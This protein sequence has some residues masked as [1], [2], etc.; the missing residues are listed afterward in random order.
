MAVVVVAW[1]RL[2]RD[3]VAAEQ[4]GSGRKNKSNQPEVLAKVAAAVVAWR[5]LPC[6]IAVAA[7][8]VAAEK[9]KTINWRF[10][11]R[12]QR[13]WWPGGDC[14]A[15]SLRQCKMEPLKK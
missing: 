2:P 12:W 10:W 13:Q 8:N 14:H 9:V 15:T 4:N 3:I 7:Q 5:R 1:R 6:D 11:Q